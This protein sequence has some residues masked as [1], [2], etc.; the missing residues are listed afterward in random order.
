[1]G[2]RVLATIGNEVFGIE[3]KDGV[4]IIGR[5]RP[6]DVLLPERTVSTRHA[7]LQVRGA[8][9]L[10]R[11]LGSSNGTF[12]DDQPLRE[13]KLIRPSDRVRLGSVVVTLQHLEAA[14]VA[15]SAVPPAAAEKPAK[16]PRGPLPW[17]A[18]TTLAASAGIVVLLLLV[19]L[20]QVYYASTLSRQRLVSGYQLFAEQ[21]T[22]LLRSED[23]SAL[24][25]PI[26]DQ[27]LAEPLML[28]ASDGRILYPRTTPSDG[29][30]PLLNPATERVYESAK[31]GLFAV[32]GLANVAGSQVYSYPVTAGGEVVGFVLASP[33]EIADVPISSWLGMT[34]LAGLIALIILYFTLGRVHRAV[35]GEMK[36]LESKIAP[37]S[38]GFIE[39]LPRSAIVPDLNGV[40]AQVEHAIAAT[41]TA[42]EGSGQ[43]T[44]GGV[45]GTDAT[46]LPRLVDRAGLPQCSVDVDFRLLGGSNLSLVDELAGVAAG[47]S[48]FESGLSPSQSRQLVEVLSTARRESGT[49]GRLT[50]TRS[51]R[52]V[53]FE[54]VAQTGRSK[55][56][57]VIGLLFVPHG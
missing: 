7:E 49:S 17:T 29:H 34:L 41:G 46:L 36:A 51:G 56:K 4:Y 18:R 50:L 8:E 27:G 32:P 12:I 55:G 30:S 21:Y 39:T 48:L 16:Q 13:A 5:D 20:M 15:P 57:E 3:L 42:E 53:E 52:P 35:R 11:D 38:N 14:P 24:P 28:A 6:S 23:H 47:R 19:C 31:G 26:L 54:V 2:V 22:H 43:Q 10:L 40:A 44:R 9:W 37:L 45:S 25:A 1:M 33:G